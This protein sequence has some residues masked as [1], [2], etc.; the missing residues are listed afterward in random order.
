M[1]EALSYDGA[2]ALSES[3]GMGDQDVLSILLPKTETTI[4]T[5]SLSRTVSFSR[6]FTDAFTVDDLISVAEQHVE[7]KTNV[8]S[9]ADDQIL[10]VGKSLEDSPTVNET[11]ALHVFEG[12]KALG[13]STLNAAPL[14]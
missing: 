8:F 9:F 2:K 4:V 11:L 6:T 12:A 14:N 1:S 13:G 7:T 3:L 5:D 10:A